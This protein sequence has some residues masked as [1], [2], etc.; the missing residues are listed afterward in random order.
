MKKI[1]LGIT[2]LAV[3]ANLTTFAS[4][5]E[6]TKNKV[7]KKSE[8]N[9]ADYDWAVTIKNGFFYPR[10]C[11]LRDIFCQCGSKG[12][13][14][15]EGAVRYNLWKRLDIEASGSY[16]G[17]KGK[18]LCGCECTKVKI[19]TFGLGLKYFFN[20][21]DLSDNSD[22][23]KLSFFL[24]AGLRI[25]FYNEKNESCFVKR[26][27]KETTVG[28]MV[29]FGFEYDVHEEIFLDLFFDYNFKKLKPCCNNNCCCTDDLSGTCCPSCFAD[30]HIGGLVVGIGLGHK[31]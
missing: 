2:F 3:F 26:C 14:W 24:G 9:E 5:V 20:F 25:F 4:R 7:E 11:V 8:K 29:N 27:Y 16:F 19:P 28:G 15:I 22:W 31:F 30:L 23:D 17:K 18:A 6:K 13:Y 1:I 21:G 10:D 12:G